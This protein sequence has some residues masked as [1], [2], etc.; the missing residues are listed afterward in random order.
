M[1]TPLSTPP[2]HPLALSIIGMTCGGCAGAV[3]A[4]LRA[5]PGAGAVRVDL[6]TGKALVEGAPALRPALVAAVE[7]AGFRVA[8]G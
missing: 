7:R 3:T 5:V 4:A 2:P 1:N 6:P 8:A